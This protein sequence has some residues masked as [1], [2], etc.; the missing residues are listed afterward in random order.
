MGLKSRDPQKARLKPLLNVHTYFSFLAQFG[1]DLCEED[2]QKVR[3]MRKT[4]QTTTSLRLCGAE[5]RLKSRRDPQQAHLGPLLNIYTEL[6][7][8]SSIWRGDRQ[9]TALF[10]DKKG[11]KSSH[12]PS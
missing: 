12:L 3:K 9:E 1:E 10:Q 7:L 6:Q 2:T 8:P 4:D 5:M 11:G